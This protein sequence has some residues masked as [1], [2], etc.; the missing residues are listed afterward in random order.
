MDISIPQIQRFLF[1]HHFYSGIRR[2][3]GALLPIAVL[4]LGYGMY[5]EGL[6]A[7]F[8]AVCIAFIDQPGPHLNRLI[9]MLLGA[10]LSSVTVALTGIASSSHGLTII[11]VG[12]QA[13][14]LSMMSVFGKKGTLIGFACLLLMTIT[15]HA[16]LT[17]QEVLTHTLISLSG[18]IFYSLFSYVTSRTLLMQEKEQALA[19]ALFA[20]AEYLAA[21]AKMYNQGE[22]IDANYLKLIAYQADLIE[23]HQDA[24]DMVLRGLSDPAHQK[25]SR[26]IMMWNILIG[27]LSVLDTAAATHADYLLLQRKLGGSDALLF[28]RD[29]LYKMALSLDRIALAVA[30]NRSAHHQSSVKAEL[31]ALEFE[32]N[33]MRQTGYAL[34]EPDVYSVCEQILKRLQHNAALIESMYQ[35]TQRPADMTPLDAATINESLREFLSR[36]VWSPR[37]I[38]SNLRLDSPY[39]RYGLRVALASV[40]AVMAAHLIPGLAPQGYWILLTV[41]MIM[42]PGFALT[43]QRNGLRLGGT[44]IGCVMAFSCFYL[45]QAQDVLL[46]IMFAALTIGCSMILV[47]YMAASAFNTLAVLIAFYFIN[48]GETGVIQARALDTFIGSIIA[49]GCSYFLPW[50]EVQFMPSLARAAINAN[51]DYLDKS[52]ALIE[53]KTASNRSDAISLQREANLAW[54]LARKNAYVAFSNF[55][56]AFYRMIAEPKAQQTRVAEFNNLM[57]QCQMMASQITAITTSLKTKEGMPKSLRTF[58]DNVSIS[59]ASSDKSASNLMA[60]PV[61]TSPELNDLNYLLVQLHRSTYAVVDARQIILTEIKSNS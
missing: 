12:V 48:P 35:Y 52:L 19:I 10:L 18:G 20:T 2:A 47:N 33:T 56:Q 26:R 17:A 29:A 55:A 60:P 39:F 30:S 43:K 37:Q 21:R 11:F 14:G 4:G 13:F 25:D 16:P 50:W 40:F 7:T 46:M 27:M 9:E 44:L 28:S 24:R 38:T 49:F 15:L 36:Q 22:D 5:K 42:R 8:G 57:I 59:L 51:R 3:V 31:R 6:V 53:I 45:T 41:V 58:L 23:K 1:S 32:L 61:F 34:K 54:R